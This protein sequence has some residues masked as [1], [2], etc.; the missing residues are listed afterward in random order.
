MTGFLLLLIDCCGIGPVSAPVARK[1]THSNQYIYL[2][3]LFR[4]LRDPD[5]DNGHGIGRGRGTE[6]G[7]EAFRRPTVRPGPGGTV[8]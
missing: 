5:N 4:V 7:P 1:C 8:G 6:R 2:L 3:A